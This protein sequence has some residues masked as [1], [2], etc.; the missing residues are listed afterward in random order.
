[1]PAGRPTDYNNEIAELICERIASG[2]SLN[3]IC[4]DEDMPDDSTFYRWK[5]KHEELRDKYAR[6]REQ[7]ADKQAD[8]IVD[9]ADEAAVVAREGGREA[10]AFVQAAKLRV[11]ARKWVASKL[12]PKTWGDFQTLQH[13]GPDGGPLRF[14][15]DLRE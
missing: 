7:Q 6:A 8:E 11:D 3:R 4:K 13:Q 9:I 15:I 10:S 1:M 2:E 5:E 14:I 12:K